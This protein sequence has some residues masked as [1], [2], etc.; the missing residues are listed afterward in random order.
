MRADRVGVEGAEAE[1][2][3]HAG[4]PHQVV[5]LGVGRWI[6][7]GR[8][9][10][11][12]ATFALVWS[13]FAQHGDFALPEIGETACRGT[14]REF[15]DERSGF[16]QADEVKDV[17]RGGVGGDETEAIG[18]A[19]VVDDVGVGGAKDIAVLLLPLGVGDEGERPEIGLGCSVVVH[20]VEDRAEA[21]TRGNLTV[22]GDRAEP[23]S[24]VG[25]CHPETPPE[26]DAPRGLRRCHSSHRRFGRND[27]TPSQ[28][29]NF[30]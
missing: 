5:V 24:Q 2:H 13:H 26:R 17:G 14:S 10:E 18:V 23:S 21:A 12:T 22:H 9:D 27:A 29:L 19:D 25:R 3:V 7:A 1:H 15:D 4:G 20:L 16:G 28:W 11:V 6:L 8:N 30:G